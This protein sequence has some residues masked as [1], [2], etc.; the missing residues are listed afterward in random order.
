MEYKVSMRTFVYLPYIHH[1]IVS[2]HSHDNLLD[3]AA[4]KRYHI[5]QIRRMRTIRPPD[6]KVT[7]THNLAIS[8]IDSASFEFSLALK[9]RST[10]RPASSNAMSRRHPTHQTSPPSSPQR[11]STPRNDDQPGTRTADRHPRSA[12]LL[13]QAS[14]VLLRR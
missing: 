8:F 14:V 5:S 13:H 11:T 4:Y 7:P 12:E 6:R 1:S 9:R 3:S 10:S 2:S